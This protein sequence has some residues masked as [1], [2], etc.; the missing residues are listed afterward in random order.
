M[1]QTDP[2]SQSL[3]R[4]QSIR[5]VAHSYR[6]QTD[7][8]EM[9]DK[10]SDGQVVS[11]RQR[12]SLSFVRGPADLFSSSSLKSTHNR[13]PPLSLPLCGSWFTW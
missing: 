4:K 7:I 6:I 12:K 11:L 9:E 5:K 8:Q 10:G 2:Q 13:P 1:A 3:G